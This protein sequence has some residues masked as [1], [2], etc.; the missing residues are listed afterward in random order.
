MVVMRDTTAPSEDTLVRSY[1]FLR[2]SVGILGLALPA[3][4]IIG[5]ILLQ[6]GPPLG[7]ISDYVYSDLRSVLIGT[8]AAIGVFLFSYRGYGRIDD[9]TANIAAVGAIGVALFP[10]TPFTGQPSATAKALGTV[11]IISAVIL[12]AAL[13]IVCLFLFTRTDSAQLAG[14]KRARNVVYITC[15]VIM[16]AS[17]ITVGIVESFIHVGGVVLWLESA[18]VM[19]FGVAWLV[20]GATILVD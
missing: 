14:R 1:L 11:H 17:L 15:G 9:I 6:G 5:T 7:S 10:T 18:A 3:V 8:M 13:T 4:L 19:A 20:K 12:F 16:L 2:R